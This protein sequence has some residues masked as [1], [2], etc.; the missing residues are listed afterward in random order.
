[1]GG[2]EDDSSQVY[3]ERWL[4]AGDLRRARDG[5]ASWAAHERGQDI[6]RFERLADSVA[7]A[8]ADTALRE[9]AVVG[10]LE[11][12]AYLALTRRDTSGAL[13]LFERLPDSLCQRCYAA[14]L[15]R[16][17]L[18]ETRGQYRRVLEGAERVNA[19]PVASEVMRALIGARAAERLSDRRRAIEEYQF[20]ADAWRH[21][22]PPLQA[23]VDEA[24]QGLARLT[25]EPRR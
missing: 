6:E 22:D 4:A 25:E 5:L 24:R 8:S 2:C 17:R 20:V 9:E 3:F 12:R 15:D 1:L 21:A 19:V 10:A 14:S 18:W 23:Y 7:R 11:A 16:L 13:S